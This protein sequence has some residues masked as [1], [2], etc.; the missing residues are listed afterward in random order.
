MDRYNTMLLLEQLEKCEYKGQEQMV[1]NKASF[2]AGVVTFP[3]GSPACV[4]G[5]CADLMG[6]PPGTGQPEEIIANFLEIDIEDAFDLY[7]GKFSRKRLAKITLEEVVAHL[8]WLLQE[9]GH[10]AATDHKRKRMI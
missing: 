7:W 3:C 4:A 10:E 2:N 5:H 6:I 8:K 1:N 9:Y